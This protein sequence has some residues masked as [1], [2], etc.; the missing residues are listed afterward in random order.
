MQQSLTRTRGFIPYIL[1][2]LTNAIIDLGHKIIIQNTIF[3]CYDG[4]TQVTLTALI[5]A[6]ILLPF[7]LF[8]TPSGFLA[9]RYAKG[10]IIRWTVGL[11]IPITALIYISYLL[12]WFQVA[13]VLT[14]ILATHSAF[15][16]PAKY[17]YIK[18]MAGQ[19]NLAMANGAVQSVTIVAILLGGVLF[20][21]AFESLIGS[22][23]SKH[24]ILQAIAPCGIFLF[25]GAVLQTL[26]ACRI[27]T[28]HAGNPKLRLHLKTYLAGT[29]LKHN[30]H[31]IRANRTI[32]LSVMGLTLFWAVNQVLFAAFG[33]YLKEVAGVSSTIVAQGLLAIGGVGIIMGSCVAGRIS[34]QRIETGIIP[35]SAIGMAICLL[36]M[37]SIVHTTTLG[38]LLAAY[39]FFGGLFVVPLNALIQSK[40]NPGDLGT[41]LAGNNFLQNIGMLAFLCGTVAASFEGINS[42]PIMY[43]LAIVALLGAIYSLRL[44]PQAL[45]RL[46]LRTVMN[47]R[48][49]LIVA[50][51]DHIP[52]R[53]GVLLLGNH[54]SWIDW[55]ILH[56]VVPRPVRFVMTRD[57]YD[58]WYLRWFLDLYKVIPIK[59]AGSPGAIRQIISFL[60]AGECV[61]LFPEGAISRNGQLAPFRRGFSMA[62]QKAGM[63]IIPFYL[64]GLWGSRWSA[65]S[66]HFRRISGAD[67]RRRI[68][69]CFGA[70]LPPDA[71]PL[72]VKRAVH[73]LSMTAWQ[74]FS[75][76]QPSL[77]ALI[78]RSLH[79]APHR[80]VVANTTLDGTSLFVQAAQLARQIQAH[81]DEQNIGILLP[82]GP[83]T[84]VANLAVLMAGKTV[85]NLPPDTEQYTDAITQAGI[86]TVLTDQPELIMGT[87]TPPVSVIDITPASPARLQ[88]R[89]LRILFR[90]LPARC[91]ARMFCGQTQP[92]AVAAIVF[93]SRVES[94]TLTGICLSHTNIFSNVRQISSLFQPTEHDAVLAALPVHHPL[95]LTMSLFLPLLEAIPLV[96]LPPDSNAQE[97]SGLQATLLCATPALLANYASKLHNGTF[98]ALRLVVCSTDGNT[99]PL[100]SLITQ[101]FRDMLDVTVY[102]GYGLAAAPIATLNAPDIRNTVDQSLQQGRKSGTEGLPLPGSAI[103]IV[104]PQTGIDL[105]PGETGTILIG[106]TQIM[107]GYLTEDG[108]QPALQ[109]DV[110]GVRWLYT[111]TQGYLDEDGFLLIQK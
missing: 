31:N 95:G 1:V 35:L 44:L 103:R 54:T 61:A 64:R 81:H 46:L 71:S 108:T 92:D 83:L 106:G 14:L 39:G 89:L 87:V 102:E 5:N 21:V 48:Y 66:D 38:I 58:L 90:T 25:V 40:A 96:C 24:D 17:G 23:T 63:P 20:S 73:Q 82:T 88:T 28:H 69:V 52:A 105:P 65:A 78:I 100:S 59:S 12:G 2:V 42:V 79:R 56:L 62:A 37:P 101:A 51:L 4:A 18:E 98:R 53:G 34:R 75:N 47:Q 60:E 70:P 32:W 27:P 43:T 41:V 111:G 93:S 10:T 104:D 57:Y 91:L 16:S 7:I 3:K 74:D 55:A 22:A 77:P 86:R 76:A 107:Q 29:Y 15:Y 84:C 9:D 45:I 26:L 19:H 8:F 49:Q 6:C 80:A 72:D 68:N 30:L 94:P 36:W 99:Q 11:G 85:V 110:N 109:R 33:A 97:P 50:G 67:R 13:F